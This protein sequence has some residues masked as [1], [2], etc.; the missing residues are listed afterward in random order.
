MKSRINVHSTG[1]ITSWPGRKSISLV[2]FSFFLLFL[3]FGWCCC[4]CR[5]RRHVSSC[6]Q[7]CTMEQWQHTKP[8][9]RRNGSKSS[10][11][12]ENVGYNRTT[13]QKSIRTHTALG[14]AV[15]LSRKLP[16]RFRSAEFYRFAWRSIVSDSQWM[17]SASVSTPLYQ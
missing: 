4:C 12:S 13:E 9:R 7:N 1:L 8:R 2:F 16:S 11:M 3:L 10:E 6:E 5:R 15:S 17:R 14:I